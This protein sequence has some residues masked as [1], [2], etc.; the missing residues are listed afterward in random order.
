MHTLASRDTRKW[1]R[2][3]VDLITEQKKRHA[4]VCDSRSKT[5]SAAARS[6]QDALSGII[7]IL[8]MK[9]G[10]V[11]AQHFRVIGNVTR[12]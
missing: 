4:N 5:V 8:S 12:L 1:S 7:S 11:S 9:T 6:D 10:S 2:V 3:E